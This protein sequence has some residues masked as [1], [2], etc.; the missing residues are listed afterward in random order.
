MNEIWH[1][2]ANELFKLGIL[3]NLEF[4]FNLDFE[5]RND[6]ESIHV[7]GY[8]YLTFKNEPIYIGISAGNEDVIESRIKKQLETITLRSSRVSFSPRAFKC[9]HQL[10]NF[11]GI[12]ID[13]IDVG[14]VAT[15][16]KVLFANENW[17][18]FS[19]LSDEN[20]VDFDFYW[21]SIP[22]AA[23]AE[24]KLIADQAKNYFK[25]RCNG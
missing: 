7:N 16:K 25:P 10:E 22:T 21:F 2:N 8:F 17:E 18:V 13:R 11:S 1:R 4:P 3:S 6:V 5:K 20:L 23:K 12:N 9:I 14:C 19:E 15:R 24:V